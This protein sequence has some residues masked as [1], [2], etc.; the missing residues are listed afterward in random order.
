MS[1]PPPDFIAHFPYVACSD[2]GMRRANNQDSVRV[3]LAEEEEAFFQRGHLFM[4]ADGMGAHAA[5]ELASKLAV[6]NVPHL[7]HHFRDLGP[8]E[9]LRRA[10]IEA[11][12]EIHRRGLANPDF[13]GMGT[14]ASV[15]VI[16][17]Q[18]ALIGHVGDSRVYRF[19]GRQLEQLTFDH[20]LQWEVRLHERADLDSDLVRSIPKNYITRS[21]G[22]HDDVEVDLEGPFPLEPGDTFL[23]CSDGLSGP[24]PDEE[25]VELLAA[26]PPDEAA[27]ALIDLANLRGGPDNITLVVVRVDQV[28]ESWPQAPLAASPPRPAIAPATLLA[29]GVAAAVC[30]LLAGL[31]GMAGLGMPAG[32]FAVV[33]LA[34]LVAGGV[35]W[36]RSRVLA[37]PPKADSGKWGRA[38]YATAPCKKGGEFVRTLSSIV[39]Q[40]REAAVESDW[41]FPWSEVTAQRRV[42]D[43]AL[44]DGKEAEAVRGYAQTIRMIMQQLRRSPPNRGGN[45]RGPSLAPRR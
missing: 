4:V 14:T 30:L 33:A 31:L 27:G 5:G 8:A 16:L 17:P 34:T 6:D 38:P 37:S 35:V 2:V 23:L 7:Y 15:L 20:S 36:V 24:I 40:L 12:A 32:F 25:L 13:H 26:L 45:P 10:L 21:L 43:A 18:G 39:D 3:V 22:P 41:D 9:A 28:P 1:N 42:A 29:G 44:R 11:N 19:R